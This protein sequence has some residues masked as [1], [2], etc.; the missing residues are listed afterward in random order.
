M[1]NLEVLLEAVQ[2]IENQSV[3]NAIIE[4]GDMISEALGELKER[5]YNNLKK[6]D[7]K[8]FHSKLNGL[9]DEYHHAIYLNN[10]IFKGIGVIE[11]AILDQLN[12]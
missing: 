6:K 2:N 11:R 12:K 5:I 1:K 3:E 8:E 4:D 10:N 7:L 9:V